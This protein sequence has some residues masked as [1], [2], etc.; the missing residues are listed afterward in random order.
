MFCEKAQELL[1]VEQKVAE[2]AALVPRAEHNLNEEYAMLCKTRQDSDSILRNEVEELTQERNKLRVEFLTVIKDAG[3]MNRQLLDKDD[4]VRRLKVALQEANS[5]PS[6]SSRQRVN[7]PD[8]AEVQKLRGAVEEWRST[9][10]SI[11]RKNATL[12]RQL[13]D[14]ESLVEQLNTEWAKQ[15][16]HARELARKENKSSSASWPCALKWGDPVQDRLSGGGVF[17]TNSATN[18]ALASAQAPLFDAI[19]NSQY[20]GNV[21]I[22]QLAPFGRTTNDGD[23]AKNAGNDGVENNGTDG[24]ADKDHDAD[25]SG[26][27]GDPPSPP[28]SSSSLSRL[29]DILFSRPPQENTNNESLLWNSTPS[30]WMNKGM[31]VFFQSFSKVM[32]SSQFS[33]REG[34]EGRQK[35]LLPSHCCLFQDN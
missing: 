33:K 15:E 23:G 14:Q 19:T 13:G 8:D 7:S 16:K 32:G 11:E 4:E 20:Q 30:P 34:V 25:Q 12:R 6:M 24:N 29:E 17:H 1:A 21:R 2:Q 5:A 31:V 18:S 9:C 3:A 27:G 22:L 35:H 26:D 28:S 10:K